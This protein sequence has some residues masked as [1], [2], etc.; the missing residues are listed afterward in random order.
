MGPGVREGHARLH[1]KTLD[2]HRGQLR[3]NGQIGQDRHMS[4]VAQRFKKTKHATATRDD[5]LTAA[6]AQA[7]KNR[8]EQWILEFLGDEGALHAE[9]IRGYR[10]PFKVAVVAAGKDDS[11][12]PFHRLLNQTEIFHLDITGIIF[13]RQAGAPEKVDHRAGKVLVRFAR[14]LRPAR[15][16]ERV[17]KCRLEIA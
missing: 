4:T 7:H 6:L 1:S 9:K 14:D 10:D 2:R 13:L 12:F 11:V 17:T 16:R 15:R 8:I 3:R 5:P